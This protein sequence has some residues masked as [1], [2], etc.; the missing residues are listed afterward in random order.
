MPELARELSLERIRA[1]LHALRTAIDCAAARAGRDP[2]DVELL[3]AVKHLS[4]ESLP[5]LAE[6]GVQLVGENRAQQ[7]KAKHDAHAG[8]F[9]WD[10]I[11]SLQS[12]HIRL[13]APRVRLIHSLCTRSA[14]FE[15][16][17]LR[18]VWHPALAALVQVNVSR[19]P[20]KA[21]VDPREL[22]SFIERCPLPVRGLATMPPFCEDPE[23][24]RPW[25]ARLRE[26]AHARNLPELSM[27][28]SQD[29]AVAV[30]E[31]ATIVRIGTRLFA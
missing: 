30:E 16:E 24:S 15:L 10:F 17:R 6:A 2:A 27:G 18:E 31:G 26:L 21:G 9:T 4:V 19:D 8:L 20:A 5:L 22:D 23:H 13:V 29:F 1:S 28:T 3:A 7:L 25:F 11:G 12:K 14:L